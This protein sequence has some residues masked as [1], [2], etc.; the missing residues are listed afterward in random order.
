MAVELEIAC[1]KRGPS[2][3]CLMWCD[4]PC[5]KVEDRLI[6]IAVEIVLAG[7]RQLRKGRQF[8]YEEDLRRFEARENNRK[9]RRNN[10][11]SHE[12][13][14]NGFDGSA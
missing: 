10:T 12:F 3:E 7:E 8:F 6:D 9:T 11:T 4:A 2:A 13:S 5:E 14:E 1:W